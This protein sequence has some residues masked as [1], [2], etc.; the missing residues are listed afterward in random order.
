MAALARRAGMSERHF[1]RVFTAQLGVP[2]GRYVERS[3]AD[4]A[5]RLL[6][7]TPVPLDVVARRCGFGSVSTLHRVFRRLGRAT[8]GDHRRR[9]H[10][11]APD[12]DA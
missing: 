12:P 7:T 6:E 5:C 9:F 10:V 8:P 3:R 1:Q 11:L 2:P 4:A